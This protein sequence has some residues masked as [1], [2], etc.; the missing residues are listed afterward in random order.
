VHNEGDSISNL[1][2]LRW[3]ERCLQIE[4][5]CKKNYKSNKNIKGGMKIFNKY[6]GK[7]RQQL[8]CDAIALKTILNEER[9]GGNMEEYEKVDAFSFLIN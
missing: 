3:R 7:L 6:C 8:E 9:F 1:E 2:I 5:S 4:V